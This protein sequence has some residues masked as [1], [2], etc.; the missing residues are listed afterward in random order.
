[1]G[2][3]VRFILLYFLSLCVCVCELMCMYVFRCVCAC[4]CVFMCVHVNACV[5]V[6]VCE[7]ARTLICLPPM[8]AR[9]LLDQKP[10]FAVL[11]VNHSRRPLAL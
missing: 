6:C 1:M 2:Y 7:R 5:C 8:Q 9:S 4:T 10:V 11:L 3:L